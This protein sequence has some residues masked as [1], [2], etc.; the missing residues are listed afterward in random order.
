MTTPLVLCIT[1]QTETCETRLAHFCCYEIAAGKIHNAETITALCL[2]SPTGY[3]GH[4]TK[5]TLRCFCHPGLKLSDVIRFQ[6]W[7]SLQFLNSCI[8]V[9]TVLPQQPLFITDIWSHYPYDWMSILDV[10]T[11]LTSESRGTKG[12]GVP[13]LLAPGCVGKRFIVFLLSERTRQ[14]HCNR[15][16]V[17]SKLLADGLVCW[18]R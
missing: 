15:Q 8:V 17:I 10:I 13:P 9:W 16:E 7:F 6:S 11:S 14:R 5:A 1:V 18:W 3:R 12:L 2:H 4:H